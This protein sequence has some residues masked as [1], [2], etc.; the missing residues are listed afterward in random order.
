MSGYKISLC[1]LSVEINSIIHRLRSL[2]SVA[3]P[4]SNFGK[5]PFDD[6]SPEGDR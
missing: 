4:L 5:L 1:K 3:V 2:L 6:A